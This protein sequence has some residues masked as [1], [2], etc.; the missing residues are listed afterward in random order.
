VINSIADNCLLAGFSQG[1][2]MIDADTVEAVARH[3]ELQEQEVD[4]I[5]SSSIQQEI[6]QASAAWAEISR[7]LRQAGVPAAL[8]TFI[9]KLQVQEASAPYAVSKAMGAPTT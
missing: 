5:G 2:R 6:M 4:S 9:Q 7:D 3:L 1:K 8:K